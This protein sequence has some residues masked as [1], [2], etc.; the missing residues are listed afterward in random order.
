MLAEGDQAPE[1]ALP[2]RNGDEIRLSGLRGETVVL[3]F[4]PRADTGIN[5]IRRT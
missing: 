1:F 2:D 3:C 4:Y 5:S